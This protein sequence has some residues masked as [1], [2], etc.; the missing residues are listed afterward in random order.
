MANQLFRVTFSGEIASGHQL[1][2]VK[3]N[4]GRIFGLDPAAV[5]K[6]LASGPMVK[7][8]LNQAQAERYRTALE[9]AGA[10]CLLEPE[11]PR[12]LAREATAKAAPAT[13][14]MSCP[15][16]GLDQLLRPA[17]GAAWWSPRPQLLARGPHQ[18]HAPSPG[19]PR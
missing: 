18:S 5:D 7:S 4:L 8:G 14:Q 11:P 15:K 9:K 19:M 6:L 13:G 1:A 16:C 12:Q 3:Q 10:V 17:P 2:A